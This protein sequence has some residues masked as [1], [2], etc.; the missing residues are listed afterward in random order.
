MQIFCI[1]TIRDFILKFLPHVKLIF[2]A[3]VIRTDKSGANE[4]NKKAK[5]DCIHHTHITEDHLN[6]YGLHVNGYGIRVLAKNLI[7]GAYAI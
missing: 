1:L 5:F 2:S 6:A 3:P 4:N 7:S